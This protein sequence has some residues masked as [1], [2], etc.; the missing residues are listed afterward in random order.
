MPTTRTFSSFFLPT[1]MR[2]SLLLS[3][4]LPYLCEASLRNATVDDT[5]GGDLPVGVHIQPVFTPDPLWA[6][7]SCGSMCEVQPD[8][9][10][11][12]DGTWR[13]VTYRPSMDNVSFSID[14]AG[15]GIY[16]Y[17]IL[18]FF[19]QG[20]GARVPRETLCNFTL[21]GAFQ[22][23]F[24]HIPPTG[25]QKRSGPPFIYNQLAFSTANLSQDGP[26]TL[27]ASISGQDQEYWIGFDYAIVTFNDTLPPYVHPQSTLSSSDD[28]NNN[29]GAPIKLATIIGSALGGA[30]AV[31]FVLGIYLLF[32]RRK[33]QRNSLKTELLLPKTPKTMEEVIPRP[34]TSGLPPRY[35]LAES[36]LSLSRTSTITSSASYPS[37][38]NIP[39]LHHSV[40]RH[41]SSAFSSSGVAPS[42]IGSVSGSSDYFS[43]Y[44]LRE[45]IEP[46]NVFLRA[47]VGEL[48]KRLKE[49]E[50]ESLKSSE[51]DSLVYT[52]SIAETAT[53]RDWHSKEQ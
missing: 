41:F 11:T 37:V 15:T 20:S 21:D 17:F 28:D 36:A 1:F 42:I 31:I 9:S 35:S 38:I 30:M 13:Q 53:L 18:E 48:E 6:N 25:E 39:P 32:R 46:E 10:A 3:L 16:I 50:E 52:D 2:A 26:H 7:A 8:Q 27:T 51:R 4:L 40:S 14:F 33:H 34:S 22:K 43:T 24:H 23:T 45:T 47:R 12:F 49:L 19:Q 29:K 5:H 44:Q